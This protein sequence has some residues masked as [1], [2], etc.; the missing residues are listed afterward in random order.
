M[1]L[2]YKATQFIIEAIE[3][4]I[5]VY[6]E[7]LNQEDLDEDESSDIINDS[8]FLEALC[9][10][11]RKNLNEGNTPNVQNSSDSSLEIK[12]KST[13]ELVRQVL[14]L[15]M[16]ERL[17]LVDTITESIRQEFQSRQAQRSFTAY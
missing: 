9:R 3:Y 13:E 2:S 4:Q 1:N 16:N 12:D 14:Q 5:K 11:L 8:G 17:S 10:D 7:R 6:Q 15:S